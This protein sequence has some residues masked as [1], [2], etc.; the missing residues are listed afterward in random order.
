MAKSSNPLFGTIS[1]N[2]EVNWFSLDRATG[3]ISSFGSPSNYDVDGCVVPIGIDH[4]PNS[5][6]WFV[7]YGLGNCS[8][9]RKLEANSSSKTMITEKEIYYVNLSVLIRSSLNPNIL[10]TLERSTVGETNFHIRYYSTTSNPPT[11]LQ[12][13][14]LG[15]PTVNLRQ[16]I[17]LESVD[18]VAISRRNVAT[19]VT[20]YSYSPSITLRANLNLSTNTNYPSANSFFGSMAEVVQSSM[21]LV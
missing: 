11:V 19:V 18:A 15:T 12:Q 8:R 16:G 4:Q 13:L 1:S 9:F 10:L 6:Y 2:M 7:T 14:D 3:D 5:S 20:I 17:Y 21:L